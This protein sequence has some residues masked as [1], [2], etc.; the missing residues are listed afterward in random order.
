[1][2][3]TPLASLSLTHVHYVSAHYS[4]EHSSSRTNPIEPR[5]PPVFRF[6]MASSAPAGS[7]RLLRDP[8]LGFQRD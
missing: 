1:M 8:D 6:G 2:G 7:L 5:G 3:D 4:P